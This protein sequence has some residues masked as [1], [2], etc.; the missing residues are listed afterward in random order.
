MEGIE[1]FLENTEF[2]F[3]DIE[4]LCHQCPNLRDLEISDSTDITNAAVDTISE[5]LSNLRRISLS[6]CYSITPHALV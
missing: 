1:T 3:S 4:T 2:L 5:N 6:R